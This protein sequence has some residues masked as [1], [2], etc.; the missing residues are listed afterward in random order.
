MWQIIFSH[1]MCG[2]VLTISL[3]NILDWNIYGK[4]PPPHPLHLS[5]SL[6]SSFLFCSKR[7]PLKFNRGY[8]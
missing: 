8:I 5:L 1:I 6:S 4:A 2:N 7:V 3:E